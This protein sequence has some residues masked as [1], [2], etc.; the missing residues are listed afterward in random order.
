LAEQEANAHGKLT[1]ADDFRQSLEMVNE[2]LSGDDM[3]SNEIRWLLEMGQAEQS[4]FI[5]YLGYGFKYRTDLK[6]KYK[7]IDW[8]TV[9]QLGDAKQENFSHIIVKYGYHISAAMYQFFEHELTGIWKPF[10][11]V[12]QEKEPPYGFTILDSSDWSWE[13]KR[14]PDGELLVIPKI[15]AMI[16]IKLMDQYIWC[17]ENKRYPSYS[18]FIKPDF[19]GHRIGVPEAPGWYKNQYGEMTF[20]NNK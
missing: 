9:A 18:V 10:F 16:F 7:M 17:N 3:I 12:V 20:Y 13:F 19:R 4:H 2:L 14:E 15:G 6:T 11:W 5:D 8:K 1:D